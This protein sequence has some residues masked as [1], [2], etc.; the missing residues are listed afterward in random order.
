MQG[1]SASI[2]ALVNDTVG[3]LCATRYVAGPDANVGVAMGTG[4]GLTFR[5]YP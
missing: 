5:L 4:E 3:V 2:E 1:V